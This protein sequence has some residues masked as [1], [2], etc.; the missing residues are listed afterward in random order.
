[1]ALTSRCSMF[2]CLSGDMK[3]REAKV[4]LDKARIQNQQQQDMVKDAERVHSSLSWRILTMQVRTC[5]PR[6]HTSVSAV[7]D[8]TYNT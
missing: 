8:G 5:P 2:S 4:Q 6:I 1:M 3:V 7:S